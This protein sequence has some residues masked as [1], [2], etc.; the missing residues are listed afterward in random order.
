MTNFRGKSDTCATSC[1]I[2]ICSVQ[3]FMLILT[4]MDTKKEKGFTIHSIY[5]NNQLLQRS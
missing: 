5:Y 3:F 4:L 1:K 2:I